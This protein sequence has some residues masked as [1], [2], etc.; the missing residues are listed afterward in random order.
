MHEG[1]EEKYGSVL[2]VIIIGT[3]ITVLNSSL[4]NIALPNM[5]TVFGVSLQSIQWVV[6]GYTIALGT[7]IP[8]S[9]YLSDLIGLKKLYIIALAIF[10]AGSLLCGLSW[11]CSSMIAFR[12]IQ[13]IGG[14]IIGPVGNA[15]LFRSVPAKKMGAAMG[16]YGIAAMAAPAIGPTLGG[17]IIEH[18]SWRMLFYMSVPFGVFGVFMGGLLLKEFPKSKLGKFDGIGFA[19]STI[20]LICLFYVIGKWSSIDWSHMQ[21]SLM[22]VTGIFSMLMFVVNEWLHPDPLLDLKLLKNYGF[23][24]WTLIAC[25][26]S[27]AIIGVS[28]SIPMFLQNILGYSAMKTGLIMLPAAIAT[29]LTMPISGKLFDKYG[30]K[31]IMLPGLFIYILISCPL[32]KLNMQTSTQTITMMLMVRGFALGMIMMPPTT[33]CMRYV[34][35]SDIS[36]A[37]A[38]SNIM[39]QISST[40][41][42]AMITSLMQKQMTLSGARLSEQLSAFDPMSTQAIASLVKVY[43]N[44]G[45]AWSEAKT[46]AM[47]T[48]AGLIQKQAYVE[49]IDNIL[50]LMVFSALATL[51]LVL[52]IN[53]PKRLK[54]WYRFG[55]IKMSE[56]AV[57]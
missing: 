31:I 55:T 29:A 33:M 50:L 8:L 7:V 13:G 34:Q 19:T 28:Y 24:I 41:V 15:I 40:C 17:Y 21:Y 18:V 44:S 32:A 2:M 1:I 37:T 56:E 42:V 47:S 54:T 26:V 38:L 11:N 12:I 52:C 9:G 23:T 43:R 14:G 6:T 20:G 39:R 30:Y 16:V 27:M 25:S 10:T 57:K 36:Q 35:K 22:L 49:A 4:I 45:Y 53:L 46:A 5:M 48:V 3:F 51:V